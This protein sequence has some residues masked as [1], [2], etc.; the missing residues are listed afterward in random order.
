[1]FRLTGIKTL[2]A[3]NSDDVVEQLRK[4]HPSDAQ[5]AVYPYGG[6]QHP[7]LELDDPA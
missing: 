4:L 6:I 5:V 2:F 1:M 7:P 3:S